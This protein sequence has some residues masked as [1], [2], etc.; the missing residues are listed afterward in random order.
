MM[1]DATESIIIVITRSYPTFPP[2]I[3]D[4]CGRFAA[5]VRICCSH[6]TVAAIVLSVPEEW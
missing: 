6:G 5:A 4:I 1:W 3:Q 2:A